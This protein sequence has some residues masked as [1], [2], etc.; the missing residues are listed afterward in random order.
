MRNEGAL[1]IDDDKNSRPWYGALAL[2]MWVSLAL[3]AV[4]AVFYF[5]AAGGGCDVVIDDKINPN[6]ACAA[7][8]IR[9]SGIG[10]SRAGAIIEYRKN[11]GQGAVAFENCR[12]LQKVSG[13]GPKT[14]EK[15][16]P[17]L[18]FNGR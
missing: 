13:I 2:A 1:K 6:K 17:R 11:A 15:I 8:M 4:F 14:V 3:S 9:L 12:D 16:K 5:A 7:S 18:K 10:P